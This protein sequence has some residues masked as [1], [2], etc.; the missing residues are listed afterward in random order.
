MTV[1]L[2]LIGFGIVIPLLPFYAEEY[3]ASAAEVTWLMAAYSL[4]QFLFAPLWGSAS[5]RLAASGQLLEE[6]AAGI[7]GH[8]S[9][10]S[11]PHRRAGQIRPR[12]GR[13]AH[14][15]EEEVD[16]GQER[17]GAASGQETAETI[18][19]YRSPPHREFQHLRPAEVAV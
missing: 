15:P 18:E 7:A 17:R 4:A 3:G 9:G 1:F 6:R 14:A 16:P 19:L 12:T 10:Q 5:D 11:Q 8:L 13:E 2:D